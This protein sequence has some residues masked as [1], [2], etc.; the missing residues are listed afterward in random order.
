MTVPGLTRFFFFSPGGGGGVGCY[1]F[2]LRSILR[3]L[4]RM[5]RVTLWACG[6]T[7][8]PGPV[9]EEWAKNTRKQGVRDDAAQNLTISNAAKGA[10]GRQRSDSNVE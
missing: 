5:G 1:S 6:L 8:D 4:S 10:S 9:S 3:L 7:Q 2:P